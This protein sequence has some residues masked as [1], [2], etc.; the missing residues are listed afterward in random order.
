MAIPTKR[1]KRRAQR[2][3][4]RAHQHA[5]QADWVVWDGTRLLALAWRLQIDIEQFQQQLQRC[6]SALQDAANAVHRMGDVGV[7]PAT[8][9]QGLHTAIDRANRRDRLAARIAATSL[10]SV[11]EA[12]DLVA[13]CEKHGIDPG[14]IAELS[15]LGLDPQ[16]ALR[17]LTEAGREVLK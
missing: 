15:A 17:G 2:A 7:A 12:F 13:E 3:R 9:L 10:L 6:G 4:R 8:A 1:A 16:A 14:R 5:P 11:W